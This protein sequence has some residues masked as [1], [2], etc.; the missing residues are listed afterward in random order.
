MNDHLTITWRWIIGA[1]AVG[2]IVG[3]PAARKGSDDPDAATGCAI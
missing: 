3:V 2:L 1:I